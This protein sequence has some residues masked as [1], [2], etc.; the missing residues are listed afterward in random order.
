MKINAGCDVTGIWGKSDG[1][2]EDFE[3]KKDQKHV[4]VVKI[5]ATEAN[6]IKQTDIVQK[7]TQGIA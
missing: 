4:L 3:Q 5:T 1:E 2:K 6:K 7:Q